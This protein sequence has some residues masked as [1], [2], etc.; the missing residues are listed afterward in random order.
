MVGGSNNSASLRT[1]IISAMSG[2]GLDLTPD[3][4][5]QCTSPVA[6]LQRNIALGVYS[7]VSVLRLTNVRAFI[8]CHTIQPYIMYESKRYNI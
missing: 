1:E 7:C 6:W 8:F 5:S 2:V 4:L 3:I